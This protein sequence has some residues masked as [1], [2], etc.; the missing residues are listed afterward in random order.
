MMLS[1][2]SFFDSYGKLKRI[3][4]ELEAFL[5][6]ICCQEAGLCSSCSFKAVY[7]LQLND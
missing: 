5:C 6:C 3:F 2:M 7:S 1:L 4:S